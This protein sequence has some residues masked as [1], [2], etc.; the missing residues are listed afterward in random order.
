M[1]KMTKGR[2]VF[3]T[4]NLIVMAALAL[5]CLLPLLNILAMSFSS[6]TAVTAGKVGIWPVEF[7]VNAYTYVMGKREFWDSLLR[8]VQRVCIEIGR[9]SCRERV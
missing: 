3:Q 9:A 7:N 5:L 4:F 2:I 8:S 1:R 6:A